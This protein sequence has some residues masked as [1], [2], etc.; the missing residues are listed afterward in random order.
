M[1]ADRRQGLVEANEAKRSPQEPLATGK[2]LTFAGFTLD[3]ERR[4]LLDSRDRQV[5]LRPQA[6]EVLRVL[7]LNTGR[8]LTKEELLVSVWPGVMVTDDSLVQA[9]SDVRH[10]L[11]EE[12]HQVVKTVPRRGYMLISA[13]ASACA[14]TVPDAEVQ[15]TPK[16]LRSRASLLLVTGLVLSLIVVGAWSFLLRAPATPVDAG[17]AVQPSIAVLA[18]KGPPGDADGEALASD[19]AANLV[20]ELARSPDLRVVSNQ[21][22]FQFA[23]GQTPLPEIARHLRSRYLVDGT[24]RRD[25]V[26]VRMVVQLLDSQSGQVVWSSSHT[27]DRTNLGAAQQALVSRIA[28]TLQSRVARAEDR[29]ALTQPPKS[30]D[31]I[32]LT[33]RGKSMMQRYSA[34]GVRE[35]RRYLEQALVIDPDYA[36]AWAFLGIANTID[37]GLQLTGEW[38]RNRGPEVLVQV[39]RAVALQPDLPMAYAA[40]ADAQGLLGNFGA[41]LAA[42]Q[43]CHRL[44]PNDAVCFYVLGSAQLRMGQVEP[45]VHNFEQALDRNPLPPANLPAFYATAL[46]ASGRLEEAV[47]MA[48]DC[49]AQA[50]NFGRCRQDRI[51]ALVELG[52]IVEAREEAAR[53][54]AQYPKMTAQQFKLVLADTAAT[55][56]ERRT[57]AARVAGFP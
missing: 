2:K 29:H 30:L 31:V 56:R 20:S 38:N 15:P 55:L 6:Y 46:W 39:Q 43:Q 5:E 49:L 28:G 40:L 48:D 11:G 8:L 41:A 1:S 52:R 26:Q 10:A 19:V 23:A 44:S 57:A 17:V 4:I 33:A 47:R 36:P 35:A 53:L 22:S 3:L 45:A 18:F 37:I 32:V 34:E 14:P 54:R 25:G 16:L 9:I 24:V 13:M 7:A 27:V 51:A 42:A 12:G 50:P 21:S